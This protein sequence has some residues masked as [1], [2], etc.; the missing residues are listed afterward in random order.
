MSEVDV[1]MKQAFQLFA[2]LLELKKVY[3]LKVVQ[4]VPSFSEDERKQHTENGAVLLKYNLPALDADLCSKLVD[5]IYGLITKNQPAKKEQVDKIKSFID[6]VT[7][8]FYEEFLSAGHLEGFSAEGFSQD[9]QVL[10]NFIVRQALRP[11][12][13]KY[14]SLLPPEVGDERWQRSY[15]PVCGEKANLSYLRQEDGK[16]MLICPFCGKEWLY[17]FLVCSWCENEDHKNIKYFE[18]AEVPGYEVF[19]CEQC[20]GYL[21]TFNAKKAATHDEWVLEDVKTV[22]LDLLARREGYGGQEEKLI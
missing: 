18:V 15:C 8:Q 1:V 3:S 12:L 7:V 4:P 20:H 16:R 2:D 21:K 19:L 5:N 11:F 22:V 10:F 6:G 17:R 14:V 9:E 13:E